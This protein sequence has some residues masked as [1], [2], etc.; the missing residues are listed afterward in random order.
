[1]RAHFARRKIEVCLFVARYVF[2]GEGG[3]REPGSGAN[4]LEQTARL[5]TVKLF[6]LQGRSY[7]LAEFAMRR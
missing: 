4:I 7:M 6:S 2:R 3:G 5:T 1:M